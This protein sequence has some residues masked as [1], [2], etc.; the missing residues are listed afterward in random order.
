MHANDG[1]PPTW[2]L[3][4]KQPRIPAT[5]DA[6]LAALWN[7]R[8]H[9]ERGLWTPER[10]PSDS[11]H[12]ARRLIARGARLSDDGWIELLDATHVTGYAVGMGGRWRV[13]RMLWDAAPMSPVRL[14]ELDGLCVERERGELRALVARH[15]DANVWL[16]RVQV[17]REPTA[18]LVS[19]IELCAAR[20]DDRL[21]QYCAWWL[22]RERGHWSV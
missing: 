13:G 5:P 9:P 12:R 16:W 6:E 22:K 19:C 2:R 10:G 4:W 8:H 1:V 20:Y 15:P 21:A 11:A 14:E 3:Q 17:Y 18:H 7:E